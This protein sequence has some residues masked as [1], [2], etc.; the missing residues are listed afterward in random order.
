MLMNLGGGLA[1]IASA[2][3]FA[4]PIRYT[5]CLTEHTAQS[6]WPSLAVA[7]GYAADENVI[8][9]VM[10]ESPRLHFD[11]A[12]TEPERLPAGIGD[13]LT[14]PGSWNMW[15]NSDMV[16]AMSPQHARLCADAGMSRV[17]AIARLHAEA[18]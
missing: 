8:T 3:V 13:A 6:P 4:S 16:V 5:A 1:G 9:C 2:T 15:F 18:W 12:S 14:A 10:V 17:G 11:D 7:S